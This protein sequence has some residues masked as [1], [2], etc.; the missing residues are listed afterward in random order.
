[1]AVAA[2]EPNPGQERLHGLDYLRGLAALGIMVYHYSSWSFGEQDANSFLGR[3][4]IYGVAIFYILSGQTLAFVYSNT[5]RADWASVSDF[6]RKRAFRIFP[7]LWAATFIS[8][9]LS[10]HIPNLTDVV[11]N[12]TGLFGLFRWDK[13]FA[14]GAWSIGNELAFYVAFPTI[15]FLLAKNRWSTALLALVALSLL[16]YFAFSALEPGNPLAGQ[17]RTYINP[18][19]QFF[20][21]LS[22]VLMGR[23]VNPRNTNASLSLIVGA[24]G[25]ALFVLIPVGGD[26]IQLVTGWHRFV[27]AICCI[28]ICFSFFRTAQAQ[29]IVDKPLAL[30]G[31]ISYSLYLLHPIVYSIIK[32]LSSIIFTSRYG[33]YNVV[34]M[35]ISTA[36]SLVLS[37]LSY[38]YF[39]RYFTRMSHK[40]LASQ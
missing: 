4:G 40:R 3:I 16:T 8:I 10:K 30:L 38:K 18:L 6:Y 29:P 26:A 34:M 23:F 5:L 31:Q 17:W 24:M 12:L 14:T 9:V 21:F 27:F 2:S 32:A 35:S 28:S 22:G 25:L 36:I 1:M 13:Y 33:Y 11:L 15:L 37:Y 7:L 19:N 20:F 39:E